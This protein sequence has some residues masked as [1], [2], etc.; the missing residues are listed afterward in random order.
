MIEIFSDLLKQFGIEKSG[1]SIGRSTL[2]EGP[3]VAKKGS[4][5]FDEEAN[6]QKIKAEIESRK[7]KPEEKK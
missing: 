6:F 7:T 1:S 5:T 2:I 3:Y 4:G